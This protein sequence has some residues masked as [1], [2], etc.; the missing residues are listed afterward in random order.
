MK[1]GGIRQTTTKLQD[2]L[3]RSALVDT[4]LFLMLDEKPG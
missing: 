2:K 4:N 3:S 1:R